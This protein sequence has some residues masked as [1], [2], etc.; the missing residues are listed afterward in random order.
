MDHRQ[1]QFPTSS[2]SKIEGN[3]KCTSDGHA[4]L[5]ALNY[6]REGRTQVNSRPGRQSATRLDLRAIQDIENRRSR[7]KL[8]IS[9]QIYHYRSW[10]HFR[11]D[12]RAAWW[13]EWAQPPDEHEDHFRFPRRQES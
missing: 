3:A 8:G 4:L 6:T 12:I 7:N 11:I 13:S 1:R 5:L 10:Q 9:P 2:G